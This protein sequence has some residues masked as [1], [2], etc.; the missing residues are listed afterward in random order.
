MNKSNDSQGIKIRSIYLS[1]KL[2]DLRNISKRRRKNAEMLMTK[3]IL[4]NLRYFGKKML[5][6]RTSPKLTEP[7]GY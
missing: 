1:D 5:C 4:I 6:F 2:Y 7:H 3:I